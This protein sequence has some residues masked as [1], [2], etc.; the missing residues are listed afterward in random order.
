MLRRFLVAVLAPVSATGLVLSMGAG[1]AA[2][3]TGGAPVASCHGQLIAKH[4]IGDVGE[5]PPQHAASNGFANAGELNRFILANEAD[6]CSNL[7]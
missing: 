7:P 5:T 2:A 1:V 6:L 4:V 3:D